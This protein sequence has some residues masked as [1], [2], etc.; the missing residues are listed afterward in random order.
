MR[1]KDRQIND[2][3]QIQAILQRAQVVRLG[4]C[5]DDGWPYVVPMNFGV[6]ENAL[7]VHGSYKG[8]RIEL[9]GQNNK[10]CF[11][12]DIDAEVRPAEE[13]C[14]WGARFQ[15]VIGY[16]RAELVEGEEKVQ[17]LNIIMNKYAG[18][19]FEFSPKVLEVTAVIKLR[20]ESM[21]GK[22]CMPDMDV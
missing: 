9:L 22:R 3:K 12:V 21:T 18:R 15:S 5:G 14:K 8:K 20:I 10:V 7:Y 2:P 17:G 1:K 13:P 6:T 19:D 11:E 16:A 4:L